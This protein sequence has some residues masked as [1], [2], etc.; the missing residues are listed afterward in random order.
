MSL[1]GTWSQPARRVERIPG[2]RQLEFGGGVRVHAVSVEYRAVT[3]SREYRTG[4]EHHTYSS[5]IV[6]LSAGNR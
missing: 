6:S 3:R 1:D 5:M 2:V 4:P